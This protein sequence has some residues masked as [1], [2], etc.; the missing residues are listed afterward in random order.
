MFDKSN[1]RLLT[2][3]KPDFLT[4]VS[5]ERGT[6]ILA[7]LYSMLDRCMAVWKSERQGR[8]L[9]ADIICRGGDVKD[10]QY[11]LFP[12]LYGQPGDGAAE[13]TRVGYLA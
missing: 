13:A 10:A 6:V 8:P 5:Q 9:I 12:A 11:A 1:T 2:F 7:I 4:F 3:S